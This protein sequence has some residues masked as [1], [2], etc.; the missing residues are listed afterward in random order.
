MG[1]Q[2]AQPTADIGTKSAEYEPGFMQILKR[3]TELGLNR[4]GGSCNKRAL[5]MSRLRIMKAIARERTTRCYCPLERIHVMAT[6]HNLA[7]Y[8]GAPRRLGMAQ[9]R[10]PI[11]I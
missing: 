10:P 5:P 2:T 8:R 9:V 4:L 7:I 6:T 3:P 1:D 11:G